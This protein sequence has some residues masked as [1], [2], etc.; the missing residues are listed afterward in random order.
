M[1]WLDQYE[2]VQRECNS[3]PEITQAISV[4]VTGFP[5]RL[6]T[7]FGNLLFEEKDRLLKEATTL[8]LKERNELL[9]KSEEELK[10]LLKHI[11]DIK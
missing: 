6:Q 11:Q 10:L 5:S 7:I 3:I 1:K 9:I 2:A 8:L 4:K